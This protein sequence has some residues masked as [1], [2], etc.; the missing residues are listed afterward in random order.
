[1]KSFFESIE[2]FVL[3]LPPLLQLILG[4]L[5]MIGLVKLFMTTVDFFEDRKER[6]K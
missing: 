5:T 2:N 1:M 4:V 3:S 6:N